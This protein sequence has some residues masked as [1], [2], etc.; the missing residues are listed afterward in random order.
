MDE[1]DDN[2]KTDIMKK[3]CRCGPELSGSGQGQIPRS[4]EA[5]VHVNGGD[6]SV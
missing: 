1:Q 2:I 3:V 6:F 4:C 5:S